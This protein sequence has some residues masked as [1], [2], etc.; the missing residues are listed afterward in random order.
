MK[1]VQSVAA[2]NLVQAV[3]TQVFTTP[4]SLLR[5]PNIRRSADLIRFSKSPLID[6]FCSA[7]GMDRDTLTKAIVKKA[8]NLNLN[9]K[10]SKELLRPMYV[11][12]H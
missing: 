7:T 11:G 2:F 8:T 5:R 6:H 9:D 10:A 4:G 1:D 3:I 12:Q